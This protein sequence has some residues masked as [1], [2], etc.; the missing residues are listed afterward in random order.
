MMV[1]IALC[2]GAAAFAVLVGSAVPL[3]MQLRRSAAE[4]EYLLVCMNAELPLLLKEVRTTTEHLN[5]L[6]EQARDG[7]EHAA[8]LLHAAGA[9]GD[10]V[11]RIHET[12]RGG[13]RSL[14]VNLTSMVAGLRATTA[15]VKTHIYREG[16]TCNGR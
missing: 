3:L 10:T 14:L 13:S 12:V 11:Q 8:P 7:V 15:V 6:V 5:T 9:L 16:G 1:E 2:V 4:S